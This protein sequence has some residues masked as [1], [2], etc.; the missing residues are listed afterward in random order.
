MEESKK[1]TH[2]RNSIFIISIL[3]PF[4]MSMFC[5]FTNGVLP[6]IM[7]ILVSTEPSWYVTLIM[8]G[9]SLGAMNVCL[10]I[11]GLIGAYSVD[12]VSKKPVAIIGGIITGISFLFL[13]FS[14]TW[15]IFFTGVILAGVGNGIVAPVIFALISDA[16]P[17][18][19]RSTNYGLFFL[20]GLGGTIMV[21]VLFGQS[22]LNNIW[23]PPFV[24]FGWIIIL[25]A[26][27]I[28][29]ARLPSRGQK[30]HILQEIIE[31]EGVKYDYTIK[32]SDLKDIMK[33]KSNFWLIL[34][35]ADAVPL[36][37]N[38]FIVFWLVVDHH[39]QYAAAMGIF[40]ISIF[41]TFLTP[42]FWGRYA[43]KI[44]KKT[45]DDLIKIK[46]CIYL[47]IISSPLGVISV[48]IPWDAS[49][50]TDPLKMFL[51]PGF[52]I[53]TILLIAIMLFA[54]GINPIWKST[55]TEINLP[56]HRTTSY[57][58][59]AFVDQ[60]GIALGA[61]VAGYLIV[62]FGYPAAF[63]FSAIMGVINVYTWVRASHYFVKDKKEIENILA[64]R[65]EKIK[66]KKRE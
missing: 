18:E 64:Q 43:D 46:I 34:N 48:F 59:A 20:F 17:P 31:V 1:I 54:P 25:L 57:Q 58:I 35:F 65:A 3:I 11:F 2:S 6:L 37:V 10:A 7:P 33:R 47:I 27:L 19:R 36:G 55:M 50:I 63:I 60:M 62:W 4:L 66:A 14:P 9:I 45:K 40:I 32:F 30:D 5:T 26:L 39:L 13:G 51:I 23:R 15:E 56:E 28:F 61:F 41:L 21:L 24:I 38:T 42:V 22:I 16:T 49:G 8:V 53:V 44:Y 12:K 52:L 29:P